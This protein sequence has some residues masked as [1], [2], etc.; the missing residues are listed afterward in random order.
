M[1]W[2]ISIA[3]EPTGDTVEN[4]GASS[5]SRADTRAGSV[6][7]P[8]AVRLE[9]S[10]GGIATRT[11]AKLVDLVV[12]AAAT[13]AVGV[14]AIVLLSAVD[15]WLETDWGVKVGARIAGALLVFCGAVFAIP[16]MEWLWRGRT[17]GKSMAGLRVVTDIGEDI[18]LRHAMV[19]GLLA[20]VE[21]PTGL[22]FF[23]ALSNPRQQR[24]GDLAAG[25]IV[26]AEAVE[27][28][29]ATMIPTIFPP[30]PG[31]EQYI[32]G[33]DVTAM[34]SAQFRLV[35]DYLLRCPRLLPAARGPLAEEV[36]RAV[37]M[38]CGPP[39]GPIGA[40]IY[41]ICVASAYQQHF[42]PQV[43]EQYQQRWHMPQPH[44]R[45]PIR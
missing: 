42:C 16:L 7:T 32:A 5:G 39:P 21:I 2:S 34:T 28:G 26:I 37:S 30:V 11:F 38:I 15:S 27:L 40:E 12:V 14:L 9:Y 8:E 35:R 6:V 3:R 10:L 13:F 18:S 29:H 41:L 25:T 19:R 45:L 31:F 22:G 17:V 43:F 36:A 20:L 23:A 4:M 44:A 1:N 24:L 33:M